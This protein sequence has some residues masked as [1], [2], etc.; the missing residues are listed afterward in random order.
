MG[1]NKYHFI[2]ILFA[3]LAGVYFSCKSKP[4]T[5]TEPPTVVEKVWP[6]PKAREIVHNAV[7]HSWY[8][9]WTLYYELNMVWVKWNDKDGMSRLLTG[10]DSLVVIGKEKCAATFEVLKGVANPDS[11]IPYKE[12]ALHTIEWIN[13]FYANKYP[14]FANAVRTGDSTL[15]A[16]QL[17]AISQSLSIM[18]IDYLAF[19]KGSD[20]IRKKY[21]IPQTRHFPK[22]TSDIPID[23]D[24]RILSDTSS[25]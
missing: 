22:N 14:V 10:M 2:Q 11:T 20:S 17:E 1:L 9:F 24:D 5:D 15:I 7:M 4:A 19:E 8:H 13:K 16:R 12:H 21:N 25:R 6:V 18:Q 3:L 23:V